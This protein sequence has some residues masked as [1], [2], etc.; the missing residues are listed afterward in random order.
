MAQ[1]VNQSMHLPGKALSA[2]FGL[3]ALLCSISAGG[4]SPPAHPSVVVT[5]VDENGSPVPRAEVVVQEPGKPPARVTTDYNG[6]GTFVLEGNKPYSLDVQKPGFYASTLNES[7]PA[8]REVRMVL[9]HVQM[10]VQQVNVTASAPGID[11]EQVSDKFT[12]DLPEII[13]VPYPTSRDIR[14]LLPFYPGV[15]QDSTGQIHVDGS[16][17]W[18]TLDLL[19]GFDIRSPVSGKLAM[20]VS[21]DAVRS[22][23]QEGTR[24]PVEFG[25]ATGGVIAFYT[26][27]GD[28]RF[29][30]NATNF[31]PSFRDVN[32][33]RFDKFAPRLTFSG[34]LVR[35]RAWF[36]DGLEFEYDNVYIKELPPD[37]NTNHLLR[38]SNL[39]RI[40]A[41]ATPR[42]IVSTGLL[43]NGYHSPYDGLSSLNPQVSTTERDTIAW[44]PYV[45]DQHN[46]RNGALLDAGLGVVRFRDAYEPYGASPFE[47]TPELPSGSYF[48]NLAS[49]SQRVDGN[50][51]LYIPARQWLGKHDLKAGIDADLIRFDQSISRAPVYYLREDRT[52]LRK[53]TFPAMTP[54]TRH[55]VEIG[56]YL[57][58]RWTPRAGLLIEPGLRFDWDEIVSRP[59]LSPRIAAV[60]TPSGLEGETKISAGIGVYYEHTQLEYLTRALAGIRFDTYFAADGLTPDSLPLETNF[61]ANDSTLREARAVNWSVSAEQKIPG[62]VYLKFNFIRKQVKDEFTYVNQGGPA[63]LF[64]NYVL[65][66][67]REDHDHLESIEARRTFARGYTLFGAYTH[68]SARTS[69]AIDYVPTISMLGPQQSAPLPWDTPNR[70]LSWGWLPFLVP[71]FSKHWDFVYTLDWHTG[72]PYTAINANHEVV[73]TAGA[74]RFPEYVDFSPGLEWRFHV[75]GLYLGLRGVMENATDSGNPLVVNNNVDSPQF[76]AFSE[77]FGRALTAR[78]RLIESK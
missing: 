60:Y 38:G 24:Y 21:A 28:N 71:L 1:V 62:S 30:F 34:P 7:D 67:G 25:R 8:L 32:G 31:I 15:V 29:R 75:H 63:A 12:M 57:Q 2:A 72:F 50:V 65:T 58:D 40:Q 45:R 6:H 18:A 74:K 66:N 70:V 26:G 61:T 52:L 42:N 44:L 11:P 43:F 46:Y 27:M 36:F 39:F 5:I 56:A 47:L 49:H 14:N 68:S 3:M 16:E 69:A 19:D 77:S 9:N 35:D 20:R 22:I 55:N 59:L 51:A 37:A 76:G 17:T 33:I 41:N 48:E 73:G 13:N 78:I 53:S 64:G 54:Y 4:Q 10:V 23:D